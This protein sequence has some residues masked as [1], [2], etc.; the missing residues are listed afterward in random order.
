MEDDEYRLGCNCTVDCK[1]HARLLTQ[2]EVEDIVIF[3]RLQVLNN[4]L[5][6][7]STTLTIFVKTTAFN[8]GGLRSVSTLHIAS[9][10][11]GEHGSGAVDWGACKEA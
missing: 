1:N 9:G 4:P 7:L 3:R 6:R 8:S 10:S 2:A 11:E 5:C